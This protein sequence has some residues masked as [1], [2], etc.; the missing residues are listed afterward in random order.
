LDLDQFDLPPE[1]EGEEEGG[2][3]GGYVNEPV[4]EGN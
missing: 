1:E 2:M 4:M 3:E